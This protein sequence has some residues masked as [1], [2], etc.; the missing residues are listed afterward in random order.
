M[1]LH[2]LPAGRG[3]AEP[4]AE[5]ANW[6]RHF[7]SA[8]P[9]VELALKRGDATRWI[10][11]LARIRDVQLVTIS[12]APHGV[13][14]DIER[15][16]SP[17]RTLGIPILYLPEAG[18]TSPIAERVLIAVKARET[19][20]KIGPGLVRLFGGERLSAIRVDTDGGAGEVERIGGIDLEVLPQEASVAATLLRAAAE[21][22]A[23]LLGITTGEDADT[24]GRPPGTP[25]V[26]PIIEATER[27][28]LMW[29][30]DP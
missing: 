13:G 2:L 21:R 22:E 12:A 10:F 5:L 23:T 6:V 17:L 29:P 25:V 30:V 14:W 20:E 1:I 24:Q 27:P 9:R 4:M 3:P 8:I 28:V 26:K 7:E 15:V 19:L 18:F 16:S 11:E